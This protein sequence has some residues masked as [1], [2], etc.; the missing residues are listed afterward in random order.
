MGWGESFK[1]DG[2]LLDGFGVWVLDSTL[3]YIPCR[4]PLL[5]LNLVL[6]YQNHQSNL[7]RL[8]T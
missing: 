4:Y 7:I 3:G 6:S 8:C 5:G 1:L 2:F